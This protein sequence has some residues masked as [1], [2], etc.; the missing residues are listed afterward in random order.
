MKDLKPTDI[1]LRKIAASIFAAQGIGSFPQS[2]AFTNTQK[3]GFGMNPELT[4]AVYDE[5]SRMYHILTAIREAALA[6]PN[7]S[8]PFMQFISDIQQ[9]AEWNY[10]LI[11][12]DMHENEGHSDGIKKREEVI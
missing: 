9:E 4:K 3:E 1:M 10:M 7:I 8:K 5:R 12:H 6:E 11:S 2:Q